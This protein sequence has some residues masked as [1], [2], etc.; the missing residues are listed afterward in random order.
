MTGDLNI[1][2]GRALVEEREWLTIL[3]VYAIVAAGVA[4]Y[5]L[6]IVPPTRVPQINIQFW[7]CVGAAVMLLPVAW[8]CRWLEG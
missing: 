1:G 3:I 4:C 2:L 6:G 5:S 7:P 8:A